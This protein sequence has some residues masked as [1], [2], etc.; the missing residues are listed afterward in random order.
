[1]ACNSLTSFQNEYL[2][3]LVKLTDHTYGLQQFDKFSKWIMHTLCR[4]FFWDHLWWDPLAQRRS[5][6]TLFLSVSDTGSKK[7]Q[8][9]STHLG[10]ESGPSQRAWRCVQVFY[11]SGKTSKCAFM[12][13]LFKTLLLPM[14]SKVGDCS[15]LT[16]LVKL[17][18][19]SPA[20]WPLFFGKKRSSKT[21]H[22]NLT[23]KFVC[24]F[25]KFSSAT[26]SFSWI[27][28]LQKN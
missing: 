11:L 2:K 15:I 10:S 22:C 20:F 6:R 26:L 9:L 14:H 28:L 19:Y 12:S 16:V 1:M 18:S 21:K 24:K 3:K 5:G 13:T 25:C 4:H 17:I 7:T 8:C 27:F 23:R